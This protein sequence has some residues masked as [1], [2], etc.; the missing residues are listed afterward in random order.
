MTITLP[1]GSTLSS[2]S[3]S[4]LGGNLGINTAQTSYT[5]PT[6]TVY[7]QGSGTINA[8][9][10]IIVVVPNFQTPPSTLSTSDFV[11]TFYSSQG[12]PKMTSSQVLTAVAGS[13]SGTAS[14]AVTTV[15]QVTS[16]TF[17]ITTSGALT[18]SGSMKLV[19]PSVLQVA[20]NSACAVLAGTSMASS[21][22][23]T[24]ASLDNSI[25]FTNLNSST[26]D[27]PAQTFTL[28]VNGITNPPSTKITGSFTLTTIYSSAGGEVDTGSITGTM[29][30]GASIDHAKANITSTSAVNSATAVGYTTTFTVNNPIPAGGYILLHY[31][32]A[33]TFDTAA[34]SS[35]CF[36]SLNG[37]TATA[38]SC[39]ATLDTSYI[40]N[41]SNPLSSTA[42]ANTV[43]A[44]SV[45]G[46]ATN[47]PSTKP[48]SPFSIYTYHSDGTIIASLVNALNFATTTPS[49]LSYAQ[50]SRAS[51]TN[52][53]TTTYTLDLIQ[54]A[55]LEALAKIIVVLPSQI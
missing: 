49:A 44:L 17:S 23:C 12:Y 42:A 48:F 21:P 25:T 47:P 24:Y 22:T 32:T 20:S 30:T 28:T 33:V 13:L 15:N 34:A 4:A 31:P 40:F 50:F 29:S 2:F 16:Y 43:I 39:S 51:N 14:A 9:F 46:A 10:R 18:S 45:N 7:F 35:S 5:S 6:L 1:S 26:T 8:G 36:I 37:A 11:L 54:A 27:I 53:L 55:D 19:F 3:S 52:A 41:F 38:T